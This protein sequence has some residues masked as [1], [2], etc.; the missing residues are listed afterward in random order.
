MK[1]LVFLPYFGKVPNYFDLWM[2]TAS[3]NEKYLDF[4]VITDQNI[5]SNFNNVKI[6]KMSFAGFRKF[7]QCKFNFKISLE[8]PYKLTDYKPAYGYIFEEYITSDYQYWGFC[9]PDIIF[10]DLCTYL[11]SIDFESA[12]FEKIGDLGH[13]QLYKNT[14]KLRNLF[15]N[16]YGVTNFENYHRVYKHS[17]NYA[18][19]EQFGIGTIAIKN[20]V[21][22][23]Y[24]RDWVADIT[25][26]IFN[27]TIRGIDPNLKNYFEWQDGKL[28]RYIE[29]EGGGDNRVCLPS[30]TKKRYGI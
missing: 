7:V 14:S 23:F 22:R 17:Y 20:K 18:F 5:K 4:L 30:F 12:K 21:K 25:P 15:M 27:F 11:K 26:S 8:K 28:Y 6:K 2:L 3:R 24:C 29:N 13:F 16:G 19:D 1:A 9:D 10:G